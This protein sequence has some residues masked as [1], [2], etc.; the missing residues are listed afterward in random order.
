MLGTDRAIVAFSG[1]I[2]SSTVTALAAKAIGKN[3]TAVFVGHGFMRNSE[4]EFVEN[5]F[6]KFNIN[7]IAVDARQRILKKLRG[8]KEPPKK[9][10]S[11]WKF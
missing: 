6:R 5:T 4:P 9:K 2:D 8:A 1:G 11:K 3:L 7:F 10:G